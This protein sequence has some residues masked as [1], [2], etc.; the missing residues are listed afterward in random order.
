[1][2]NKPLKRLSELASQE[3]QERKKT[4]K[5]LN[6]AQKINPACQLFKNS[7]LIS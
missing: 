3:N 2:T 6:F 5:I 1:M 7:E 4:I